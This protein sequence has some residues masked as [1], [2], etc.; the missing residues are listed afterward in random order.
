MS[1]INEFQSFEFLRRYIA[2]YLVRGSSEVSQ[3]SRD[4]S[5]LG[6]SRVK[7]EFAD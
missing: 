1:S 2:N 5:P 4:C 7:L 6:Q 3:Y